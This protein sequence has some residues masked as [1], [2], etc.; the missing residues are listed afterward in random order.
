MTSRP[1]ASTPPS[2]LDGPHRAPLLYVGCAGWSIPAEYASEFPAG[3]SHLARY[4]QVFNAVEINS[5]FYRPH[6]PATYRRWSATVPKSFRFAVKMPRTISHMARL[7]DCRTALESFLDEVGYLDGKLGCLLLQLPP[8]LAFDPAVVLPFF[9][10]LRQL[11]RGPV[12]CE[13]RHASWFHGKVNAALRERGIT[14]VAADPARFV[15]ATVPAGDRSLQYLRLHGS[16]RMYYD[17]YPDALLQ[18]IA[19]RLQRRCRCTAERW[20]IF[21]NT[22]LGHATGNALALTGL[23]RRSRD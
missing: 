22:A 3:T 18:R 20:C 16:P 7:R 2:P 10:L 1:A 17:A 9:D 23:L 6:L 12:A 15:Q 14:R 11:H 19:L 4:A 21:D 5:S 8:S 13:P